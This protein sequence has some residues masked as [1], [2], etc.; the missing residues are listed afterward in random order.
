VTTE[1]PT[2][3]LHHR[4]AETRCVTGDGDRPSLG[5]VCLTLPAQ[6]RDYDELVSVLAAVVQ[7]LGG[8][9]FV[10]RDG[11]RSI[12]EADAAILFGKCSAFEASAKLLSAHA[13]RRPAT[14]LW[15]V[16]PLPPSSIPA[17]AENAA[18]RLARCDVNRL[19]SPLPTLVRCVP[20]HSLFFN[21]VR[22]AL[23]AQL[24]GRCGWEG[25]TGRGRVH[26]RQWYHAV[27]HALWLQQ[28]YSGTWCDFVAASTVPRCHVLTQM[29]IPCEYAPLGYHS[30]WGTNQRTQ[31]DIDVV[32]LGHV[33]R[34]GRQRLLGQIERQ[35]AQ[36][37]VKLVVADHDCYGENRTK[38]LNRARISLD[39]A[40][41]TWE[42]PVLRL[43]V[44][45]A[46]GAL[47]VSD[48][49]LDPY[50]FREEHLVRVGSDRLVAA[51]LEHLRN[52]PARRRVVEAARHHLTTEL[53]WR[54][55][56]SRVLQRALA[57][58]RT[59]QGATP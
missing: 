51:I 19:P 29:G 7:E 44:S 11:D 4:R 52:E 27:Q 3:Q 55:V 41:N 42:M 14:V 47:V 54:P 43:L 38:L 15:Q 36:A 35:L 13:A 48:C 5:R 46:C 24:V 53:A 31:R 25:Q 21:F 23:C 39:L 8:R 26:P 18:R 32:F 49:P 59:Y 45:M 50:P 57:Q 22:R 10:V 34:T 17:G 1:S 56:V 6:G 20:G 28:Q 12:L 37:G 9:A 58:R 16:E 30:L 33:K 2:K 40:K